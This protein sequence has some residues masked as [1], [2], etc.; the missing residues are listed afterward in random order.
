MRV[1]KTESAFSNNIFNAQGVTGEKPLHFFLERYMAAYAKEVKCFI[2]AI[3]ENTETPL[4]VMDVTA[5]EAQS[6]DA[7][8]MPAEPNT[9]TLWS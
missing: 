6:L 8:T 4:G 2:K 9:S 3:V 7:D 5:V 1:G